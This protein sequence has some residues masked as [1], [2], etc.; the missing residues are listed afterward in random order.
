MEQKLTLGYARRFCTST[1]NHFQEEASKGMT[2]SRRELYLQ[3]WEF[4]VMHARNEL[5]GIIRPSMIEL[6]DGSDL[7]VAFADF[8]GTLDI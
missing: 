2:A 3:I 5:K 4:A 6:I 8:I 1:L 7:P